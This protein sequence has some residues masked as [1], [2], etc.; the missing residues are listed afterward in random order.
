MEDDRNLYACGTLFTHDTASEGYVIDTMPQR[1]A[2]LPVDRKLVYIEPAPTH[3][4]RKPLSEQPPSFIANGWSALSTLPRYE[5]IREDLQRVIARNQLIE[6]V[7]R[8]VEGLEQDADT[9]YSGVWPLPP[10]PGEWSKLPDKNASREGY[11]VEWLSAPAC[12]RGDRRPGP[13]DREGE[14]DRRKHR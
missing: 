14:R 13:A 10:K 1:D 4:D 9:R 8:I 11:G 5:T 3:P 12:R 6:R 2:E 7:K